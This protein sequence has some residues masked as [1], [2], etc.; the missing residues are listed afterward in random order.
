ML[1][2]CILVI[3]VFVSMLGLFNAFVD[4]SCGFMVAL[5]VLVIAGLC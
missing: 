4:D 3:V 5:L 1:I 2:L